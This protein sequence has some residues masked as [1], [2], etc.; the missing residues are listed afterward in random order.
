MSIS[1][2]R[3]I[4]ATDAASSLATLV[5]SPP[6][7]RSRENTLAPRTA[8][9]IIVG[10]DGATGAGK[11][12][13]AQSLITHL[14]CRRYTTTL[15]SLDEV[16]PGWEALEEGIIRARRALAEL[17]S[18]GQA[19]IP[20]WNWEE[21]RPGP[22]RPLRWGHTAQDVC[23]VEG[24]GALAV[25]AQPLLGVRVVRV[26]RK[27]P[28]RLR[29]ERIALRDH[30]TWDIAAWESQEHQA[31]LRWRDTPWWGPDVVVADL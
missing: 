9:P 1:A 29:H 30:Y 5:A 23:V 27:A 2:P 12:T 24:S 4:S 20:T 6:E 14:H 8:Q 11:T 21:T 16:V 15:L 13:L 19:W 31:A 18:S 3:L 22:I 28:S 25:L 7:D 17:A 26:W 10:I